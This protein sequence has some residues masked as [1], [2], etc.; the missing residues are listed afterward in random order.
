[1]TN[2][3]VERYGEFILLKPKFNSNT[4][5]LWLAPILIIMLGFF[6]IKGIFRRS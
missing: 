2:Y 4:Y 3:L 5:F 1:M 6:L